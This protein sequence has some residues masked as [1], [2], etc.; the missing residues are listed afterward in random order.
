MTLLWLGLIVIS[1]ALAL[2]SGAYSGGSGFF[3]TAAI[4]LTWGFVAYL[5]LRLL[6]SILGASEKAPSDDAKDKKRE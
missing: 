2:L 5:A 4:Y 1:W 3:V 6:A